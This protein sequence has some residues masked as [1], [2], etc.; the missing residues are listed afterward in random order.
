MRMPVLIVLG[1]ALVAGFAAWISFRQ[2]R[3]RFEAFLLV[4]RQFGLEFWA[5]DDRG[6]LGLPFALLTKGDGRG[7]ENVLSGAWQEVSLVA[8]DYWYYEENTDSNGRTGRTYHRFSCAVTEIDAACSAVTI[9]REN[10]FTRLADHLAMRDIEFELEEFNRAFDV[11]GKDRKFANDLLDARMMRWLLATDPA[12]GFE[13]AGRW[14]LC[15][16]KRRQP[17]ELIP[18]LGTLRGFREHVPDV[19]YS[20]YGAGTGR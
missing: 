9:S 1:F 15:F 18:L 8:F 4:A 5:V 14:L 13:T 6:C 2:K 12:F 3:K 7:T 11:R 17:T 20:L 19:V 16:S 10:V